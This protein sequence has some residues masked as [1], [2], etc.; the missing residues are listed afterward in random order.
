MS[1]KTKEKKDNDGNETRLNSHLM[2]LLAVLIHPIRTYK[3]NKQEKEDAQ[4]QQYEKEQ[5]QALE[6][7]KEHK[8]KMLKRPCAIN[9][10]KNCSAEC[11]HF[12]DGW[13]REW[14]FDSLVVEPIMPL[15]KLWKNS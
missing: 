6:K 12:Q 11:V 15:C 7:I 13:V 8:L 5:E 3:Q 9:G 1:K 4:Q 10:M 2:P 14:Y